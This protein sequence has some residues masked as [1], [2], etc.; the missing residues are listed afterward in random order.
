MNQMKVLILNESIG[1]T[2]KRNRMIEI[3]KQA[4]IPKKS[5]NLIALDQNK[6]K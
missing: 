6:P 4:M 3:K 1:P 2:I 5:K